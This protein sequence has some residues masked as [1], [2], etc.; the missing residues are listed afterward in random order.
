[1]PA[2]AVKEFVELYGLDKLIAE[3]LPPPL[4]ENEVTITMVQKRLSGTYETAQKRL[5]EWQEAGRV[6]FVGERLSNGK[7]QKA[8]KV[9]TK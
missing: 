7:R 1:M 2:K 3:T 5:K 8:W 6:E 4:G 9:V